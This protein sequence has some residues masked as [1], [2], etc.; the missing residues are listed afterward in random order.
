MYIQIF[1]ILF[2]IQGKPIFLKAIYKYVNVINI[3]C[4]A[5]L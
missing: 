1:L 5:M 4:R 3:V 2:R